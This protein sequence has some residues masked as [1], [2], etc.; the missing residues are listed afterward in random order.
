MSYQPEVYS[1]ERE[2]RTGDEAEMVVG[3]SVRSCTAPGIILFAGLLLFDRQ[4]AAAPD[5]LDYF[6]GCVKQEL[7]AALRRFVITK[8]ADGLNRAE[9]S[10]KTAIVDDLFSV[11]RQRAVD[12]S[13][14]VDDRSYVDNT[15]GSFFKQIPGIVELQHRIEQQWKSD[16]DK[17][18][19]DQAVRMYPICLEGTARKLARTSNDPADAIEHGAL[20]ACEKSRQTVFD[21]HARHGK[22]YDPE[23]MKALEQEFHRKL[24]DVVTRTRDDVRK[25]TQQ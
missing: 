18:L 8:G 17:A 2:L 6:H 21:I 16:P 7:P 12:S 22:S 15:V 11:C 25:A 9:D 24:P 13:H 20:A 23:A 4:A 19:E 5:E 3:R 10:A 14:R 1:E